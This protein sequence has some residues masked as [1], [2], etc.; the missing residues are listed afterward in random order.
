MQRNNQQQEALTCSIEEP[1]ETLFKAKTPLVD[2]ILG[3]S[4]KQTARKVP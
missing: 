2:G 4:I 3:K 1:A